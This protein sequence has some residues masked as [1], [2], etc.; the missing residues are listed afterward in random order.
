MLSICFKKYVLQ[1]EIHVKQP[2]YFPYKWSNV[3]MLEVTEMFHSLNWK[4]L[5]VFRGIPYR[6]IWQKTGGKLMISTSDIHMILTDIKLTIFVSI[7]YVLCINLES[8]FS[9][10]D[11]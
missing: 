7:V 5:Q 4:S 3:E 11:N 1:F 10:H 9:M 2:I 8:V 6:N